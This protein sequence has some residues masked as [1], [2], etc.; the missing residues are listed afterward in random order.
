MPTF[1]DQFID[2]IRKKG[3]SFFAFWSREPLNEIE[4]ELQDRIKS[5]W[6]PLP[7][8]CPAGRKAFAVDGSMAERNFTNAS[9]LF[10]GQSL[11]IG[12]QLEERKLRVENFRGSTD[13]ATRDRLTSIYLREL[14][15][16]IAL[17][18]LERMKG[19]VLFMDGSLYSSL[20]HLLY[21][22][23][24]GEGS[25]HDATNLVLLDKILRLYRGAKRLNILILC[26]SKT[27]GDILL[28]RHLLPQAEE[29]G[30]TSGQV[31]PDVELLYRFTEKPGYSQPILLGQIAFLPRHQALFENREQVA[32]RFLDDKERALSL[33]EELS[34]APGTVLFYWRPANQEDVIRV[35][36]PDFAQGTS[37]SRIRSQV[38]PLSFNLSPALNILSEHYGGTKVYN[39]LLY[40]ADK[41]VRLSHQVVDQIY[42]GILGQSMAGRLRLDRSS[43]RFF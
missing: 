9:T 3:P 25:H 30:K 31:L 33:F 8:S 11:L 16:T 7:P 17:E 38:L 40:Q 37:I 24:M 5:L 4:R 14:E 12:P 19:G 34:E 36:F 41:E 22:I 21:P 6:H 1:L 43:R 2:E 13:R 20:P 39:A 35:D 29:A 23:R 27:S 42:L 32:D 10:I 18:H 28:S 26:L 15:V